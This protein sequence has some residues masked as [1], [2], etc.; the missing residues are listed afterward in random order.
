M[1]L[2]ENIVIVSHTMLYGAAHALRDYL[3]KNNINRLLFISLPFY[4]QRIASNISYKKGII[5]GEISIR[6]ASF[7]IIDYLID[8]LQVAWW[9]YKQK[10]KF[11]LF[12]GINPINCIVGLFFRKIGKTKKVIFYAIDFTPKRF[13]NPLLN[14]L[15]HKLEIYC[16][17]HADKV[18]NVSPRI[19]EGREQF[20]QIPNDPTHQIVVPIGIWNKNIKK[21]DFKD[22]KKH[23]LLFVGHLLEKQGV[24]LVLDATPDIIKKIPDFKFV[25][26]GGGEYE[27][28]LRKKIKKLRIEKYVDITG[29]IKERKELDKMMS[30]SA[31]AIAVYKPEEEKLYNFT[32]YSDPTKL[33]DYL[34]AGLPII[35]TDVS[36]NALKIQ[37]EKCGIIVFYSSV[38][39]A[40]AVIELMD[41][42][43]KLKNFKLNALEIAKEFEWSIIFHKAFKESDLL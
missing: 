34:G 10:D 12:V 30:E 7:G 4:E 21:R 13:E 26:A 35:L 25:I 8:T 24:Q 27:K 39:I 29:W 18:W 42:E 33:K 9:I 14:Y 31:C 15:Y 1:K 16:V 40:K 37:E 43:E 22:V 6:R 32:Y 17:V 2:P 11:S 28:I 20:L 36:Y 19:A 38:D 3:L 5:D 23:Q 41:D